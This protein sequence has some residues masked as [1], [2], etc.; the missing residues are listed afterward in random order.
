MGFCFLISSSTKGLGPKVCGSNSSFTG[1]KDWEHWTLLPAG[2]FGVLSGPG[3]MELVEEMIE[4]DLVMLHEKDKK[5]T[6][7]IVWNRNSADFSKFEVGDIL[8]LLFIVD[9]G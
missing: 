7:Y 6:V 2:M 1:T 4:I 5:Y 3:H 9:S 8:K